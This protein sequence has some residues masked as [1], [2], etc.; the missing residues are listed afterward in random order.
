MQLC[1]GITF[2]THSVWCFLISSW[3]PEFWYT[4]ALQ[5]AFAIVLATVLL[6]FSYFYGQ[7]LWVITH[8]RRYPH[9]C[10][11]ARWVCPQRTFVRHCDSLPLLPRLC[12]AWS[13][14]QLLSSLRLSFHQHCDFLFVPLALTCAAL[15]ATKTNRGVVLPNSPAAFAYPCDLA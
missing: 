5:S 4:F 3:L 8:F 10:T 14:A 7:L 15:L 6:L 13:P 11:F 12:P 9:I 1:L 2:G